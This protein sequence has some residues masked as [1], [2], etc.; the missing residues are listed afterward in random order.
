LLHNGFLKRRSG[1][2]SRQFQ[3]APVRIAFS[4]LTIMAKFSNAA[5]RP[6]VELSRGEMTTE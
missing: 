2:D 4:T 1:L 6:N 5:R 3:A